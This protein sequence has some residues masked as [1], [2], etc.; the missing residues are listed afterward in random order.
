MTNENFGKIKDA[1]YL[2]TSLVDIATVAVDKKINESSVTEV[3]SI[4]IHAVNVLRNRG[5]FDQDKGKIFMAI[6]S[7]IMHIFYKENKESFGFSI[8]EW[9]NKNYNMLIYSSDCLNNKGISSDS[10]AGVVY[11]DDGQD[12]DDNIIPVGADGI[13]SISIAGYLIKRPFLFYKFST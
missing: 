1:G 11:F 13:P 7:K 8:I 2:Y 3:M 9:A 5:L 6:P 10:E 12:D 4:I